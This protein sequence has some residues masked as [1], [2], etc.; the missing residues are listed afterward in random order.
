MPLHIA[1][2]APPGTLDL[3]AKVEWL[4]CN[5]KCINENASVT[6]KLL[7]GNDQSR[8]SKD[9]AFL[10]GWKAR[11]PKSADE[12]S[13]R[14][15]WAGKAAQDTRP[16]IVE[17]S[18]VANVTD[19]DFFPDSNE[20]FEVQPMAE[21][22]DSPAGKIRLR[23]KIKK[24]SGDWPKSVSGLLI[25]RTGGQTRGFDAKLSI[26]DAGSNDTTSTGPPTWLNEVPRTCRTASAI[27]FIPWI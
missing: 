12:V 13:P 24:L 6:A 18:T 10:E 11:I 4:E 21:R 3:N 22:L 23:A 19:A 20:K 17:W 16:L 25:E 2:D 1:K 15:W 9:A 8:P 26:S 27:P 14:S 7:V 5:T